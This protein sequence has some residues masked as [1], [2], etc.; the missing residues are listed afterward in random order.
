M[1][2]LSQF[3]IPKTLQKRILTILW[4][5]IKDEEDLMDNGYC[6]GSSRDIIHG[7]FR[8]SLVSKYW[9]EQVSLLYYCFGSVHM[10]N[11]IL[12]NS[13]Q[14]LTSDSTKTLVPSVYE[15][16]NSKIGNNNPYNLL[17]FNSRLSFYSTLNY[18]YINE[19]IL[20]H[21]FDE[22]NPLY[23]TQLLFQ[24]LNGET[25]D[26]ETDSETAK[27][28]HTL[29]P[30]EIE[31][32]KQFYKQFYS[33]I[34]G[35]S[36]NTGNSLPWMDPKPLVKYL[37]E[38]ANCRSHGNPLESFCLCCNF[39]FITYS[40]D[41]CR[42]LKEVLLDL[43]ITSL[44]IDLSMCNF[45]T[46]KHSLLLKEF[47]SCHSNNLEDLIILLN[48]REPSHCLD[49]TVSI[50]NLVKNKITK[51]SII[52][53]SSFKIQD[54]HPLFQEL[55]SFPSSSL[56]DIN[57]SFLT[58]SQT[59]KIFDHFGISNIFRSPPSALV[60]TTGKEFRINLDKITHP[61]S[62][63]PHI[64]VLSISSNETASP[65]IATPQDI[66]MPKHEPFTS[67]QVIHALSHLYYHPLEFLFIKR[68]IDLDILAQF[69]QS[70]PPVNNL[71][72]N[73]ALQ[74]SPSFYQSISKNSRLFSIQVLI[75]DE[76][77]VDLFLES[78]VKNSTLKYIIISFRGKFKYQTK[79]PLKT[80]DLHQS[81][82]EK[83]H[84]YHKEY[85]N[86]IYILKERVYFGIQN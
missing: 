45:K 53:Y 3:E 11:S 44:Q 55:E 9:F 85:Y 70:N 43:R 71:E 67:Q 74:G 18:I 81:L 56:Q 14:E 26:H 35:F 37:S 25:Y 27:L 10:F 15:K 36:L 12:A 78:I 72:L 54:N 31:K 41:K 57:I 40:V 52:D 7:R 86:H 22:T 5:L 2:Q 46:D 75:E 83:F 30:L 59:K 79:E 68:A 51:L 76:K 42:E 28:Y 24:Q 50:L 38:I 82:D 39:S 73:F 62:Y 49:W 29:A 63:S 47:I 77:V 6:Y 17:S 16:M 80:G 61:I 66:S 33:S 20:D 21:E 84:I 23:H 69:I 32:R 1:N 13:I 19:D 34:S 64:K 58:P 48:E 65:T 8:L 4:D 60:S